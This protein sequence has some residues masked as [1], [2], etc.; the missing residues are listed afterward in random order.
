M[1]SFSLRILKIQFQYEFVYYLQIS[2]VLI[3]FK[4]NLVLKIS[5]SIK[6]LSQRISNHE[7]ET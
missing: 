7:C 1:L 2:L 5:L 3:D 4:K 6:E